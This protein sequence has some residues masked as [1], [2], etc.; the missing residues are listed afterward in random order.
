M[1]MSRPLP[2]A[3]PTTEP[4]WDG[5]RNHKIL[6][7]QCNDCTKWVFYPRTNCPHCLSNQLTWREVPGNATIYS[8]TVARRPTAPHFADEIPQ[9]IAVVELAQGVRMNTNI[10]NAEPADLQVGLAL[11]PIF[12]TIKDATLLCF[13][14]VK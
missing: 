1:E 14:P 10:V 9:L 12:K 5:V 13:E 2:V 3:T 11:K 8:F 7:Q 4:F 6:L